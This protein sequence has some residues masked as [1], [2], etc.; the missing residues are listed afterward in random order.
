MSSAQDRSSGVQ[1]GAQ[2]AE[3]SAG[4]T[5]TGM[6]SGAGA[7]GPTS[8]TPDTT[9]TTTGT[10]RN[11]G[12]QQTA[13]ASHGRGAEPS[14]EWRA[15]GQGHEARSGNAVGGVL[16]VLA[17][18]LTFLAGLGFVI[19]PHFYPTLGGY[20]YHWTGTG[21]GWVLLILGVVL[22]AAGASALLGVPA[23]R[24]V[25]AGLAVLAA[26]A[27]FMFLVY[28]PFW[29]IVLV[30]LSVFAIWGLLRGGD[31]RTQAMM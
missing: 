13:T 18:L 25:A 5:S 30:A 2:A 12:T 31:D 15:A 22:F 20:A 27:G 19:R 7:T 26:I 14:A 9:G 23:A 8:G 17:G 16:S 29:G 6:T 24:P 28:A 3:K 11:V 10:G 4:A 1:T 21:W